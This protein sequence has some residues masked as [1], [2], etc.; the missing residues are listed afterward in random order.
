MCVCVPVKVQSHS[1]TDAATVATQLTKE[2][3][4]MNIPA[5]LSL[6]D[7]SCTL[8]RALG[9]PVRS[10]QRLKTCL[11]VMCPKQGYNRPIIPTQNQMFYLSCDR[12][13]SIET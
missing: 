10:F 1:S 11:I 2:I 12:A 9:D 8:I 7:Y 4:I 3:L 13:S 6:L 5:P